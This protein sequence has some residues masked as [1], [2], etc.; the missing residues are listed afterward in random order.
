LIPASVVIAYFLLGI[1][2][3]AAQM[4]EPFSILPMDKMT[5][6]IRLSVDEHVNWKKFALEQTAEETH[7]TTPHETEASVDSTLSFY[8]FIRQ[9][10]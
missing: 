8:D 3:L 5:G 1:E 9:N 4:E 6:G 7:H 10:K 2:E